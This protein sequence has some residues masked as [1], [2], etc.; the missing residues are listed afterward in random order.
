[1]FSLVVSPCP[2]LNPLPLAMDKQQLKQRVGF[3]SWNGGPLPV[4]CC[5]ASLITRLSRLLK[6]LLCFLRNSAIGLG[7]MGVYKDG[8]PLLQVC[9]LDTTLG[10]KFFEHKN[11][12]AAIGGPPLGWG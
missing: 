12:V 8:T 6:F 5:A 4:S 2:T 3:S 10:P 1:M 9:P 11:V 7:C